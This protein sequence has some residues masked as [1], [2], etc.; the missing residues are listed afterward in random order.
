MKGTVMKKHTSHSIQHNF[1]FL[2]K[3]RFSNLRK[4]YSESSKQKFSLRRRLSAFSLAFLMVFTS[5]P[6]YLFDDGFF[7]FGTTAAFAEETQTREGER[8]RERRNRGGR[9]RPAPADFYFCETSESEFADLELVEISY[10][11]NLY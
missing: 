3:I 10:D 8:G 5:A 4:S 1:L 7:N 2:W 9:Y 11:S 6:V